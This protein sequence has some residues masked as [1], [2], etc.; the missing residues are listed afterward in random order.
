MKEHWAIKASGSVANWVKTKIKEQIT[1]HHVVPEFKWST[2]DKSFYINSRFGL[3]RYRARTEK[4]LIQFRHRWANKF[5]YAKDDKE[6]ALLYREIL[7]TEKVK[8]R[9]TVRMRL[10]L[11]WI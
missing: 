1:E 7:K 9:G 2:R 11:K 3:I 4:D 5:A 8:Y 10:E 6:I